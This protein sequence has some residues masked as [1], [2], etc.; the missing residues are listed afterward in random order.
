M[1]FLWTAP[2]ASWSTIAMAS[3][4]VVDEAL[5]SMSLQVLKT[6]VRA[7][8]ANAHCERFIGRGRRTYSHVRLYV[9]SAG[10]VRSSVGSYAGTYGDSLIRPHRGETRRLWK[11]AAKKAK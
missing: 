4:L 2:I 9:Q 7:A 8:Q 3:S 1:G 6:P 5:Q 10:Y 11:Q